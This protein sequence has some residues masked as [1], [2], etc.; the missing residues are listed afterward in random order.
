MSYIQTHILTLTHS[1]FGHSLLLEDPHVEGL[2]L[3]VLQAGDGVDRVTLGVDVDGIDG[4]VVV[5]RVVLQLV[6]LVIGWREL[7]V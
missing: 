2:A 7:R 5:T 3:E 6:V 4:D 1:H